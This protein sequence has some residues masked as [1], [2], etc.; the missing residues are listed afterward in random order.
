MHGSVFRRS[1]IGGIVLEPASLRGQGT[2][3]R[4]VQF[5]NATART[6]D[7]HPAVQLPGPLRPFGRFIWQ[8]VVQAKDA[9]SDPQIVRDLMG[10]SGGVLLDAA[11]NQDWPDLKLLA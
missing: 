10:G 11:V 1:A 2:E 3:F 6:T 5:G 7:G 8:C 4:H 9:A